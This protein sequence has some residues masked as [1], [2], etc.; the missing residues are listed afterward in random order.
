MGDVV[1]LRPEREPAPAEPLWREALGEQLRAERLERA[2]RI[3]DV[4]GRAGMSPQY[5]S[6]L[7][8]G[9]KEPSSELL[10]AVAGAL[11]LSVAELTL[12]ISSRLSRATPVRGPVCLAA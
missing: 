2:D 1:P 9:L 8:R 10:A 12:R 7:E 4:A 5:L 3:V 11:E 6:E